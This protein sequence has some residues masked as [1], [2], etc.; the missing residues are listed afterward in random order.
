[1]SVPKSIVPDRESSLGLSVAVLSTVLSL[2]PCLARVCAA[3]VSPATSQTS[4]ETSGPAKTSLE[5]LQ[6]QVRITTETNTLTATTTN[7]TAPKEK[8]FQWKS[9]WEGWDGLHLEL[10]RKRLLGQWVSGN[11]NTASDNLST[12]V[13]RVHL[14]EGRMSAKIGGKFAVDGAAF[15]TGSQF[16][17]FDA[18]AELRRARIYASGD[19]LLLLPVSYQ[20]ELGYIPSQF[21]IEESYLWFKN[22]AYL[23]NLKL[24]QY[25][26]PMGLDV[27]TSTRDI[28]FME[29]AAPM[30]A[31]APGVNAGLQIGHPVF[32]ERATWTLGLFT[33][34]VGQDYGDASKDFGR[35]TTRL[36]ALPIYHPDPEQP[37]SAQLLHLGLSANILYSGNSTVRYQ[38]RPE[39]HLAPY[40]VDTGDIASQGALVVGGEV[41]WINGPLTVQ[42][43]YLHSFVQQTNSETLGF[44][45]LYGA[46][47]WFLTGETRPYNRR[48]GTFGRV[49]PK[50]NFDWG[51]GGWGAWEIAGRASYV[52]LDSG[53]V[54]GGRLYML[55]A[56]VNWHLHSH[57]KW[58]FDYGFGR[59]SGRSPEGNLNIFQTRVEVNF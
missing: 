1:M 4:P 41:A 11:T 30:Q 7:V 22:I 18:G 42:G 15:A 48:D 28:P 34:G 19:C 45:G 44:T 24:G 52:D 51:K 35:L 2:L 3:E 20:F 26:A 43:E 56:G 55:M 17:G 36:T 23:G 5:E 50:H 10:V 31:L 12:N 27:I 54:Q 13:H 38:A 6:S 32:H 49:L 58:R 59:V 16:Q 57:A 14:E 8:S 46:A 47:S 9:A 53:P 29:P 40:V 21:Y 39:S 25:Q 37:G 33:G